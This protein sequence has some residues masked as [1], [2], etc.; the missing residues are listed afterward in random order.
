MVAT[1]VSG[2]GNMPWLRDGPQ[3]LN[4]SAISESLDSS[5]THLGC[6]FIDLYQLHWPDRCAARSSPTLPAY[7]SAASLDYI[8][9]GPSSK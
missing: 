4:A 1:K 8:P 6:D 2:P 3:A 5:L 7:L 9:K